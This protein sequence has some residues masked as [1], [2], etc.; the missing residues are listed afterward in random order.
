[1]PTNNFIDLDRSI[2]KVCRKVKGQGTLEE[3]MWATSPTIYKDLL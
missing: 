3:K 2:L 1:M